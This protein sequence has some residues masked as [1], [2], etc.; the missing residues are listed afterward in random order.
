M[1]AVRIVWLRPL[2]I[3]GSTSL[4]NHSRSCSRN[5][6][7]APET[8]ETSSSPFEQFKHQAWE[9]WEESSGQR[10]MD[11]LK[12]RVQQCSIKFDQAVDSVRQCR[13]EVE[14]AQLAHDDAAKRHAN[15]MMRREQWDSNDASS[16]V[17]VT[18]SDVQTRQSLANARNELRKAEE[19]ASRCQRD[20]MDIMRQRYHE[21]QMWQDK[22]RMMSTYGTWALI[23]LNSIVFLGSQFFHQ[24]REVNRLKA[25]E[26]LITENLKTMQDTVS[27]QV[28]LAEAAAASSAEAATAAA[29]VETEAATSMKGKKPEENAEKKSEE[30]KTAETQP[31]KEPMKWMTV[32]KQRDYD[33]VKQYI[34]DFKIDTT[35]VQELAKEVHAPS[36]ALG[37]ATSA[38]LLLV[39]VFSTSRR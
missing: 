17:E 9:R 20:Y 22:W 2:G 32:I 10:E 11:G 6:S 7:S 27:T 26:E 15:L 5:L 21:E 19:N 1:I 18:A 25:I 31:Q 35:K 24:R 36:V 33:K 37:A 3:T 39:L 30:K 16:F 8:T 38:A 13:S 29:S 23:G 12:L 4:A 34:K 14:R 28:E